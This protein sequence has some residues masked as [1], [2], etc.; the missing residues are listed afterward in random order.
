MV[1]TYYKTFSWALVVTQLVERLLP[2]PGVCGSNPVIGK[3]N[4]ECLLSTVMKRQ[5]RGRLWLIK[6]PYS[7]GFAKTLV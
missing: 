1:C 3:I 2:T 6:K 4:F 5:K 7:I